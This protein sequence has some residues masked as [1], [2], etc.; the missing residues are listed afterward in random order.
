M[1]DSIND[2][3]SDLANGKVAQHLLENLLIEQMPPKLTRVQM[4][5]VDVK[6]ALKDRLQRVLWVEGGDWE[7]G[8]GNT[9]DSEEEA[10][11]VFT[12]SHM[13]LPIHLSMH[14]QGADLAQIRLLDPINTTKSEIKSMQLRYRRNFSRL[15]IIKLESAKIPI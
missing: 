6:S 3:L 12:V 14:H 1:F 5:P 15:M 10:I 7:L 8:E 11:L 2:D 13:Q 9:V 4:H